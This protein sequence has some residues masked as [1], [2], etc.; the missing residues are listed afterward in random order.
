MKKQ[1][2]SLFYFV[3][4]LNFVNAQWSITNDIFGGPNYCFTKINNNIFVGTDRYGIYKSTNNG[5]NWTQVN[6]GLPFDGYVY[7]WIHTFAINGG[8]IFAGTYG[9]GVFLS[10]DSGNSWTAVN[11]GLTNLFVQ[12][13][14]IDSNKIFVGTS[15]GGVYYSSNNGSNWTAK[16]TGFTSDNIQ[17]L[18]INGN[19]IFA[20]TEGG[21][22]KSNNNGNIW[23]KISTGILNQAQVEALLI[24]GN[25]IF[26]GTWGY[27]LFLNTTNGNSW[28][29]SNNGFTDIDILS[30][31]E[32]NNNLFAGTYGG[33]IYIS[34]DNGGYWY[35]INTGFPNNGYLTYV[36]SIFINDS[37]IFAGTETGVWKRS[38]SEV[39]IKEINKSISFNIYPNPASNKL[40]IEF[41][42]FSF[43]NKKKIKIYDIQGRILFEQIILNDNTDI[44]ISTLEKG[45]YILKLCIKD[46][47][48]VT[49]FVKE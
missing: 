31:A 27:G 9:K 18:L 1:I 5:D 38:L 14:A 48:E 12:T 44:D 49:T 11:T 21:V 35:E 8:N 32:N 10:S 13:I 22:Y 45:I 15:G 25:N 24:K 43:S 7:P 3:L 28:N 17:S 30:L 20:G 33:G 39:D 40:N 6:N 4:I 23:V 46:K 42:L 2:I 37:T 16:N 41:K 36:F 47:T 29:S 19:N 26:A 34:I